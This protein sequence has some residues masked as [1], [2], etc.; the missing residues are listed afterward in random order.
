MKQELLFGLSAFAALLPSVFIAGVGR[1]ADKSRDGIFWMALAVAVAGPCSWVAV[2]L[3]GTWQTGLSM[4]LWVTI[5]AT[6][7]GFAIVVLL[8]DGAWRLTPLVT[9]YMALLA[10]FAIFW[11]QAPSVRPL[12]EGA[13]EGWIEAHIAVSVATYA[14]ITLAAVAALAA[15]LQER[16]LKTKR[17]TTLSRSL[18]SVVE[19]ESLMVR[20]LVIGEIVLA[21]GLATGMATQQQETGTLLHWDHK[22]ILSL[23]TFAV[24]AVLLA[25]HFKSGVRGRM[26]TRFVLVAY[27]LLSLGYPGVKFVTDVLMS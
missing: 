9:P 12:T 5:A 25:A 11:Q 27:L 8:N 3:S 26:V 7:L 15:F 22:T 14:L 24:V 23:T 18:P 2:Q 1:N 10:V 21:L 4:T 20:L 17:P 6:M 19:S 16:A 13:P